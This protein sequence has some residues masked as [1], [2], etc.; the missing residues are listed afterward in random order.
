MI[1]TNIHLIS[2]WNLSLAQYSLTVQNRGLKHHSFHSSSRTLVPPEGVAAFQ[3]GCA[4]SCYQS[5]WGDA[6]LWGHLGMS[7]FTDYTETAV[8][9][10][11]IV[12]A[13]TQIQVKIIV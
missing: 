4:G 2:T 1:H 11:E 7:F 6:L 13:N 5:L 9:N 12:N 10:L 3:A 8:H